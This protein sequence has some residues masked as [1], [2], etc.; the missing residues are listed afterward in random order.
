MT[1]GNEMD[2]HD[3][4]VRRLPPTRDESRTHHP[5]AARR[6][7]PPDR[8]PLGKMALFSSQGRQPAAGTFLVDCSACHRETPVSPVQLVRGAL[9]FSLHLPFVRKY[10]SL[11]RCP[12]CGRHTWVRVR[13]QP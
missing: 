12:A 7:M 3:G 4:N 2:P 5:S 11:M 6:A 13:W 9:P 10:H 8:D 1:D